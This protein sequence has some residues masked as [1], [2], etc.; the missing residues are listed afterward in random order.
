[1]ARNPDHLLPGDSLDWWRVEQV[2]QVKQRSRPGLAVVGAA[3]HGLVCSAMQRSI[4][5]AA[6][7]LETTGG[8]ALD[9]MARLQP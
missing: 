6:E 7:Q 8:T 1:M 5:R 4:A 2:E 3:F 9:G